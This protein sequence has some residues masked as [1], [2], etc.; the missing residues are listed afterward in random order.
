MFGTITS[1]QFALT[2]MISANCA[3]VLVN[4]RKIKNKFLAETQSR[5]R[6]TIQIKRN[7]F[8]IN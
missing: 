6:K 8:K 7:F 2:L 3:I 4:M 1:E 5:F